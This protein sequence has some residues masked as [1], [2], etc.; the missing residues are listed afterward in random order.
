[1]PSLDSILFYAW[2]LIEWNKMEGVKASDIPETEFS[3]FSGSKR[4][5]FQGLIK[6]D[7]VTTKHYSHP[8]IEVIFRDAGFKVETIDRIEYS[9]TTEFADPPRWLK[10]PYPWDWLVEVTR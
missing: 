9:W 1:M 10:D 8:E 3:Y 7:G 2:R 4:D 6:I 5:I